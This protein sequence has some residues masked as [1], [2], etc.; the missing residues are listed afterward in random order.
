MY[1][2]TVYF[3]IIEDCSER[4]DEEKMAQIKDITTHMLN[5]DGAS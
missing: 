2:C 3:Q 4:L 5:W 1:V